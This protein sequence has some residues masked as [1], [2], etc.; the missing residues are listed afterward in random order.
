M[1]LR[2]W[3]HIVRAIFFGGKRKVPSAERG[4]R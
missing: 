4:T 3:V 1:P 2:E